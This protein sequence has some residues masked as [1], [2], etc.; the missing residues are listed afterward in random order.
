MVALN[1]IKQCFGIPI[2]KS[3]NLVNENN[4]EHNVMLDTLNAGT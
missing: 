3:F 1:S 4:L 2:T